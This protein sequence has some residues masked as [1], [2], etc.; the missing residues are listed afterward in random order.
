MPSGKR[1]RGEVR[2]EIIWT[3]G[4]NEKGIRRRNGKKKSERGSGKF[5]NLESI[6]YQSNNWKG[7]EFSIGTIWPFAWLESVN[8]L[9]QRTFI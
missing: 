2:K 9:V 7:K 6:N 5:I 8:I 4:K 1:R 3:A